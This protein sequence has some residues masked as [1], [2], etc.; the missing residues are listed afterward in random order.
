M[1]CGFLLYMKNQNAALIDLMHAHHRF[2]IL[3]QNININVH[4]SVNK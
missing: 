2:M 3:F 4:D 1:V